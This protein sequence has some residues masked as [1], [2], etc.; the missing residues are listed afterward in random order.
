MPDPGYIVDTNVLV[1][2]Q[3][4]DPA[5]FAWSSAAVEEAR[6]RG[7]LVINQ[8]IYA[9]LS[10][11]FATRPELDAALPEADFEREELPWEAAF[12]AGGALRAYRANAGA[13]STPL[14]DFYIGAHAVIAGY[15]VITRDPRRFRTYFP[16][17]PLVS[18]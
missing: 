14:G 12:L 3:G 9:E 7:R 4:R 13:R 17:V 2:L 8:I 18:P 6:N 15:T 16:Q 1:D 11:G 10:H 5:W